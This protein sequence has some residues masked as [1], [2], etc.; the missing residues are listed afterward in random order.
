MWREVKRAMMG[1]GELGFPGRMWA[2]SM[3]SRRE[4][5]DSM[6]PFWW[7][8]VRMVVDQFGVPRLHHFL[9]VGLVLGGDGEVVDADRP[10][11]V[12]LFHGIQAMV[13]AGDFLVP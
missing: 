1:L 3:V 10:R 4:G 7:A 11:A 12:V 2:V 13:K 6:A 5:M 8:P 9:G